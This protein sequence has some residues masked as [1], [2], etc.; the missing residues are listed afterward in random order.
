MVGTREESVLTGVEPS[1]SWRPL[2]QVA[3]TQMAC[4]PPPPPPPQP[5]LQH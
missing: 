3:M 2:G 5:Q 4:P 1:T